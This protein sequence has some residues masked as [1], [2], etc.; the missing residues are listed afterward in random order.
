MFRYHILAL[1]IGTI[2]DFIIGDPQNWYHPI[3]IVGNWIGFLD[4]HFLGDKVVVAPI[5]KRK[6]LGIYLVIL[7]I[8]PALIIMTVLTGICYFVSPVLGIAFEAVVSCYCLAGNS[9][10]KESKAVVDAYLNQGI[11]DARYA[12]SMIVGRDTK[13]LSLQEVLK[14]TIETIAENSS[15]GVI[16]PLFYLA[17]GGPVFGV[18]YKTINTMDSMVGY[19]NERYEDFGCPAAKLD[20]VMNYIPSRLTG[21]LVILVSLLSFSDFNYKNSLCIFKRDRYNHKSP[22]SAQSEAA[23][24][25]ALGVQL[26]GGA[27]YFGKYMEKPTIGDELKSI[28]ISDVKRAHHLLLN[29]VLICQFVI[30]VV[31]IFAW[32]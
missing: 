28:E 27:S 11:D 32:R 19:H 18:L 15:D 8:M 4:R 5:E 25:G 13:N 9:L 14:A 23:F 1:L 3:R 21:Y 22:N 2:L 30:V 12:L 10:Y 26:G 7:V 16:A 29:M 6:R 24:A 31:A 20:D 17:I